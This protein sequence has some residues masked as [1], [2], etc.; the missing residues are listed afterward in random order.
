MITL[1]L[2]VL[3]VFFT[4]AR[5]SFSSLAAN[6]ASA[7]DISMI[8]PLCTLPRSLNLSLNST[9]SPSGSR[10]FEN[11]C[12]P[13]VRSRYMTFICPISLLCSTFTPQSGSSV[14][15]PFAFFSHGTSTLP[16]SSPRNSSLFESKLIEKLA[17]GYR[18]SLRSESVTSSVN[19]SLSLWLILFGVSTV[20]VGARDNAPP[21]L[22]RKNAS[23]A[24]AKSTSR[25]MIIVFFLLFL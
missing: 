7:N 1:P 3:S 25:T 15:A 24:S 23:T 16:S 2:W 12:L 5:L 8:S 21:S 19:S 22:N 10:S 9:L 4:D 13:P 20:T 6:T 14:T 18:P 11:A 17:A